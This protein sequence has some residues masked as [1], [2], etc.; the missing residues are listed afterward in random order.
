MR[1][2]TWSTL[3]TA[4]IISA[5]ALLSLIPVANADVEIVFTSPK[6][7]STYYFGT[8]QGMNTI[9][10]YIAADDIK[11]DGV[12]GSIFLMDGTGS[13]APIFHLCHLEVTIMLDLIRQL[14]T[15]RAVVS[16]S[17]DPP[18][19]YRHNHVRVEVVSFK[20]EVFVNYIVVDSNTWS[21]RVILSKFLM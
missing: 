10:W 7:G 5:L 21:L 14:G 6:A 3:K 15:S 17:A 16:T 2:T 1:F 19:L 4:F 12:Y 20:V 8:N 13:E 9:D 18:L 11:L